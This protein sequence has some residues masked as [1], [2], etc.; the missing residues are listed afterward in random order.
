MRVVALLC[1][2]CSSAGGSS[3]ASAGTTA[4]GSGG[5]PTGGTRAG[6]AGAGAG[7]GAGAT[8]VAGVAGAAG[9]A[10]VAGVAGETHQTS[11]PCA[12]LPPGCRALCEGG[13][14]QCDCSGS[15]PCPGSEP[16]QDTACNTLGL[17]GYGEPACHRVFEC[18]TGVWKKVA[19]TCADGPSGSCPATQAEA[20]ATPCLDRRCG[21]AGEICQCGSPACSGV[22]MEPR[23][24][25]GG[26]TPAACLPAP[27]VGADCRPDGQRCGA[28]CCG[29]QFTCTSGKWSSTFIPCPP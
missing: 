25:C 18:F 2:G 13:M 27:A 5:A 21:Y 16:S 23:T 20:L 4:S 24:F 10:G 19:D 7:G 15:D 3:R 9:V 12:T 28:T 1:V 29:Q 6:S 26:V 17:C 11:N 8:G 14:C 22:F